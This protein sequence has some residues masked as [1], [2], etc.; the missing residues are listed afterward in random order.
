MNSSKTNKKDVTGLK[1]RV[2]KRLFTAAE[3]VAVSSSN[4]KEEIVCAD[5]GCDHGYLSIYLAESGICQKVYATDI[6]QKPVEIAKK[7]IAARD[8]KGLNLS[9][10]IQ[11]LQ[12]DG[13]SGLSGLGIN[14]VIICGMGGEVIYGIISRAKNFHTPN[15]R[16][17]LQ[18]MSSEA[19]LRKSLCENGFLIQDETLLR[20]S[21]RIYTVMSVIYTG[22]NYKLSEAELILGKANIQKGGELL[23][24]LCARKLVHIK[25]LQK[26]PN[27]AKYKPLEL[28][29]TK[30]QNSLNKNGETKNDNNK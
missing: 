21:G 17:A 12:C 29:L 6:N 2:G 28:E 18:P 14:R 19:E 23:K 26:Q 5:V 24:E 22:K 8:T 9:Q 7:N 20:D 1:I 16:F 30:I 13:L 25:N 10:K 11:V 4:K 15:M 27:G 3:Y